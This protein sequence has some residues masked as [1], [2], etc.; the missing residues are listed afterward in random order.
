VAMVSDPSLSQFTQTTSSAP[1]AGIPVP[2]RLTLQREANDL[3]GQIGRAH[4]LLD[5]LMSGP[6]PTPA[7]EKDPAAL[8]PLG[9]AISTVKGNVSRLLERLDGLVSAVGQL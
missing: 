8:M 2:E 3:N 1:Y 4:A 6:T 7:T 9:A 5:L